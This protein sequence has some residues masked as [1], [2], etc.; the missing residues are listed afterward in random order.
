MITQ[1]HTITIAGQIH[2]RNWRGG[3]TLELIPQRINFFSSVF[4][5]LQEEEEEEEIEKETHRKLT[6]PPPRKKQKKK[7]TN[8]KRGMRYV[9]LGADAKDVRTSTDPLSGLFLH[10]FPSSVPPPPPPTTYSIYK[11]EK[12]TEGRSTRVGLD[13]PR[14]IAQLFFH[15]RANTKK[16]FSNPLPPA[17][18]VFK[19]TKTLF[20]LENRKNSVD[21]YSSPE[22]LVVDYY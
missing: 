19:K 2:I 21:D 10:L 4:C 16:V 5:L 11:R 13:A 17:P 3:L 9:K 15:S 18:F 14:T 20:F 7:N 1:H 6:P 8:E 12:K 22:C